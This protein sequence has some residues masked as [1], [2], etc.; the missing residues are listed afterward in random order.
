MHIDQRYETQL[1]AFLTSE[2]AIIK[3]TLH[4]LEANSHPEAEETF[5]RLQIVY[6]YMLDRLIS[7][8]LKNNKRLN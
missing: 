3:S 2:M 6:Q 7:S 5:C 8:N 4:G 1:D